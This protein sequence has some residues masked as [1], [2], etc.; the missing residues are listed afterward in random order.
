MT[1]RDSQQQNSIWADENTAKYLRLRVKTFYNTD[2][3]ERIV[4]PLLDIPAGARVLDV[5]CGYGGLSLLLAERRPDLRLTG[6]DL[7]SRALESATAT[8]AQSGL[9]NMTFEHG[10]CQHLR[11]ENCA[12]DAVVCQTLLTH[13]SNPETTVNEMARVMKPG[14][15]FMAAEYSIAGAWTSSDN[16]GD[17]NRDEA[18]YSQYFRVLRLFM[19]GKQMLG[20]G[21]DQLGVRVPLLATAAGLEVFDLRVNDRALCVIPPYNHAKQAEYLD[22]LEAF[23]AKDSDKKGFTKTLEA[24]RAAGGS[25]EDAI[26]LDTAVDHAAIR[27]AIAQRNLTMISAY[28][29]YLTFARKR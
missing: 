12:F 29:M 28:L 14:G 4:L 9:R 16:V 8:A 11:F 21:D 20:R 23:H 6:V 3:F 24:V 10:D 19:R 17:S 13:V 7:E 26:W 1:N 5:G 2:Y 15:V 25:D 27:E 22:V 18:W